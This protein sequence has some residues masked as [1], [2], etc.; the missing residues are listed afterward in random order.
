ME[1]ATKQELKTQQIAE[2]LVEVKGLLDS[3]RR[4]SANLR[5]EKDLSKSVQDRLLQDIEAL[6]HERGRLD[7]LNASLQ[8]MLNEREQ[9]D[10]ETRRRLQQQTESLESEL[11]TTKRKLS[12]ETEEGK[13][14]TLRK[15]YELNQSQ[16]AGFYY[17]QTR[18]ADSAGLQQ[19]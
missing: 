10:S 7:Q 14:I 8:N 19:Y 6:R 18:A 1:I 17:Q 16:A 15:D 11:Q 3:M 12:E 5:A 9:T 2:E 13:K 4:E